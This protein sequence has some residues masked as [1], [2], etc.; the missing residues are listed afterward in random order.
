MEES[1]RST[2]IETACYSG[3]VSDS[4]RDKPAPSHVYGRPYQYYCSKCFCWSVTMEESRRSTNIETACYSGT[5]SDSARDK[6]AP[7]HVYGRPYQ[8]YCSKCFCWSVTMEESRRSTNIETA[9]YSGTVSDSARDKPARLM[10]MAGHTNITVV[11]VFVG[12]LLWRRAAEVQILKLPATVVLS[13]TQREISQPVSCLWQAIP[14]LLYGTVSDSARDKPARLMF[15]AGHTN[16]TVVNVFVGVLLWRR[17]AE[18]QILKLPA[19]VVLS[20]TQREIS[21]PRLM[22]MAGHTNITVVNVF[23]GVL[24]WRRAAEVQI[25]K[26]PATVVLSLTQREISQPVSCLWQAIPILL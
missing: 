18:V 7:S 9:C 24:L 22:F 2:N 16:I 13:L 3:T 14:I 12:V 21:Q 23:V 26:L 17:A 19:T 5:V 20:L 10:F 4:A 6:P 11:N 8:Y 15:M 25:L 1:R